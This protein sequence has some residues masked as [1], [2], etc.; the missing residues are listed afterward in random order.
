V[1]ISNITT[2]QGINVRGRSDFLTCDLFGSHERGRAEHF[3]SAS[4]RKLPGF[5]RVGKAEVTDYNAYRSRTRCWRNEH[6]VCW[7]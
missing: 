5:E 2:P 7:S 3:S 1:T 6:Y 4:E